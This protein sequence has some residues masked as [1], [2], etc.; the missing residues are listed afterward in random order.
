MRQTTVLKHP[1]RIQGYRRRYSRLFRDLFSQ[2]NRSQSAH[3]GQHV[4]KLDWNRPEENQPRRHRGRAQI[5]PAYSFGR[6]AGRSPGMEASEI[7]PSWP[8][9]DPPRGIRGGFVKAKFSDMH[10]SPCPLWVKREV[11]ARSEL[12]GRSSSQEINACDTRSGGTRSVGI[13]KAA[14]STP[15]SSPKLIKPA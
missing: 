15:G 9:L 3:R 8:P 12:F 11:E 1:S 14:P 6:G 13:K 4:S 10:V 7:A 2:R 5:Y